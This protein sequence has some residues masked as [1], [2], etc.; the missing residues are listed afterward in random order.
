VISREKVS[1]IFAAAKLAIIPSQAET[2]SLAAFEA[3]RVGTKVCGL[4]GGAVQEIAET[5]GEFLALDTNPIQSFL[6][7]PNPTASRKVLR[8]MSDVVGEYQVIYRKALSA[9]ELD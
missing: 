1:A 3:T 7:E 8:E 2:F 9:S 4:P 5:F 6:Q